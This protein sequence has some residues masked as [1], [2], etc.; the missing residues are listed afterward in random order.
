[1]DY[2]KKTNKELIIEIEKLQQKYSDLEVLHEKDISERKQAEEA[3]LQSED[4]FRNI[5]E[6]APIAMAIVCMNGI[7]EFIN[8][9]A[10]IVFGYQLN[11]IPNMESWWVKAYP[12][13]NYR[14]EVIV[15]WMGRIQ[16]AIS[17][18]N[19]IVG[20]EYRV[21][22]KDG[23]IKKIFIY[24][25]IV[26]GKIFVLFDDI[27]ERK[28]AEEALCESEERFSKAFRTSPYAFIIAIIDD[29]AIIEI[30]EAFTMVSGFTREEALSS[31]TINLKL[32]VNEEDRKRFVNK[33]S[34]GKPVVREETHLR[35][36]NGDI[37]IVLL[38][39][40][41]IK[42][43]Q[44]SCII[45]IVEDITRRKQSEEELIKSEERYRRL[46][47]T[48]DTGYVIIDSNGFVI[49]ANQE[50]VRLS[51]HEK[52]DEIFGRSVIEW[53]AEEEKGANAKA[54]ELCLR[55]GFIR[56][57]EIK[58]VNKSNK[59]TT[60][61]INATIVEMEG[62]PKI[63]SL[64]RDITER[65]QVEENLKKTLERLDLA[66]SAAHVGIW[67]WDIPKNELVWDDRMYELYGIKREDFSR[68]YEAWMA[69]IHPDDQEA[70]YKVTQLALSG[71]KEYNTEFRVMWPDETI[72]YLRAFGLV[73]RDTNGNPL[74]MTGTNYDI[75][76]R[77]RAENLLTIQHK[78]AHTINTSPNLN[79]WLEL[80]IDA[81][82]NSSGMDCGGFYLVNEN[83]KSL[84]LIIHIGFSPEFI[85]STSY[86]DSQS[87]NSKIVLKGLPVY[88][89]HVLLGI[90]LNKSRH[91]E[92]LKA[93]AV[94]PV[95]YEGQV[96]GCF[97]LGSHT[98]GE[99]PVFARKTLETIAA[100]IGIGIVRLKTEEALRQSNDKFTKIFKTSPDSIIITRLSDGKYIEVNQS[101]TD[102]T[103]F[104]QKE[105]LGRSSLL[106]RVAL[107]ITQEDYSRMAN[108][109]VT[110]GEVIGME[111][112]LRM[113]NASIR[114]A[115]LSARIIEINSE[116]CILTIAHDI[117]DRKRIDEEL[118]QSQRRYRLL[119][120][121]A[122]VGILLVNR[123]GEILEVNASTLHILG[124]PSIE[125]TVGINILTFP[126]LIKAGISDAFHNCV[127]TGQ[128]V[129]GE[130]PYISNWGKPIY[131]QL[132]FVPIFDKQNKVELVHTII[133][134]ITKR[135]QAE[136]A[137]I[138]IA[139]EW[140]ATFDADRDAIW[141]LDTNH[142]IIRSNKKA[143][144]I[145]KLPLSE[146]IGK[147]C[148]EIVHRTTQPI[149]ECPSLRARKS[150]TRES[151]QMQIG[152]NWF[153]IFVDPILDE[154]GN[155]SGSVHIVSDI[156][157]RRHAE[158]LL[159][160]KTRKIE[161]QNEEFIHLN[162]ELQK[163]NIELLIAKEKAETN[164]KLL[165]NITDNIPAFIA[166]VNAKTLQ[167]KFVNL[168]FTSGFNKKRD[169]IIGVHISE[170]I[171]KS[172]TD[173]AMKFI[174]EVRQGKTSSY[175]NTFEVAEGKRYFNVNYVPG[176]DDKGE[177]SE[178]IVL[179]YDITDIKE[180][181]QE[182]LKAK[183]KAE[184]SD[185][186][187]TA[188]LQNMSHEIRTPMNAIMGFSSLLVK[189]YND[190][191]KL[192]MFSEIINQRC[193]DLLDII[194]DILD[195]AKI[196]SGQLPLNFEDCDLNELFAELVSFFIEH[197]KRTNKQHIKFSLQA[198]D[199]LSKNTI[200]TD[201]VKLKQIFIN[202]IGNAF[203]FTDT[204]KIEGGCKLD[205]NQNLLFYLSDTGIGIPN[206]KHDKVFERFA[207]L[208][209]VKN[210]V[211]SGTGLGLPIVKGLVG[212]MGGKIWLESELDKGTTFYFSLPYKISESKIFE[213][214][215]IKE[216][217]DFNFM[218]KTI[219]V[220]E[221]DLYNL[222]YI[223]EILSNSG[224]NIIHTEYGNE[225]IQILETQSID[226]VLLDIRL[227][228][229]TG[230]DVSK[231]IKQLKP[232]L[233]IIAQTA[234]AAD[235]DRQKAIEAGCIA[236]ISKP[237]KHDLLLSLINRHLKI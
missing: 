193:S 197:Q 222:A 100:Q 94:I 179:T 14:K 8:N 139:Q 9:K 228:D 60:V 169:D 2:Q 22:C 112:P 71:E 68:T 229:L 57:F 200:V 39:A 183:E 123:T 189:N 38:S 146:M 182:L 143:E 18:G 176:L 113:K 79:R 19:E 131:M 46:V 132:Q 51:G 137:L 192:E 11:D 190:K 125:A 154:N 88:T 178:I 168:K 104:T 50:Y 235:E 16:D 66:T 63:L 160:E 110:H 103:G 109:L 164:A 69:N 7:V 70:N 134:D 37:V 47:E 233:K 135:K 133:E 98:H 140:Q 3:L 10:V 72:H 108:D 35:K 202:L 30:N 122:P 6:Q 81:A 76:A 74:R 129:F 5:V 17:N 220:V 196:E 138:R 117:T 199:N 206:D 142:K 86:F 172:N 195:I 97:N 106:G 181:E 26:S 83:D 15:D 188:F 204:G 58:Y 25:A 13:E 187:K 65:K 61:E 99:V 224:L 45:S 92:M 75:T 95:I 89:E 59:R 87:P 198:I 36:K 1:M 91:E 124:S 237:L 53:T 223:K 177:V 114:I 27:T 107:W 175:I 101:F 102:I 115:L 225:A 21:T 215:S 136:E 23:I 165:R 48:T 12:E 40:Q 62:C 33:L 234:Y 147:H 174:N 208:G 145:F 116:K 236:Y 34:N 42:L 32:W 162:K 166:V 41:F 231:K 77:K 156:T 118:K 111:A 221:D 55:N 82:L 161:V 158:I 67:D 159:K 213:N 210:Q 128:A 163:A 226:L 149:P 186:L 144:M 211:F 29:G 203:K 232:N 212:L 180:S 194:N 49:D 171:G 24:G 217:Q 80:C 44:K 214:T 191:P 184:E 127:E 56:N 31:S 155:Y 28:K 105:V 64:C 78:L 90:P 167:Y 126:L 119:H 120:E 152:Q 227:P 201:K 216:T 73:V 96:I 230:Y 170:I 93:I 85:A 141:L 205:A 209:H 121:F 153:E 150:L 54:V 43:G 207:Q 157:E 173:F 130:Y 84:K 52:I 148:W 218:G 185:R 4:R 151:M 20:N 219:L